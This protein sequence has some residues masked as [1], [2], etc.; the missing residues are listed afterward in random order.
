MINDSARLL[1][2]LKS[3]RAVA[4]SSRSQR[5]LL[6]GL[7]VYKRDV[8]DT[9]SGASCVEWLPATWRVHYALTMEYSPSHHYVGH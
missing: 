4:Q 6:V 5:C 9:K 7:N 2:L 3:A 8:Y 1:C